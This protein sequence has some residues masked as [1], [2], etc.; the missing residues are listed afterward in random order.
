MP[1]LQFS[2]SYPFIILQLPCIYIRYSIQLRSAQQCV[3]IVI[4]QARYDLISI[5]Q[6]LL[7]IDELEKGVILACQRSG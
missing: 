1:K 5:F 2:N 4:K 7:V 3:S 6:V